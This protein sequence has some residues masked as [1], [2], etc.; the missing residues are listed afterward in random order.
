MTTTQISDKQP[1]RSYSLMLR[2]GCLLLVTAAA[3][4][5][6]DR[7]VGG[8][9]TWVAMA[10]GRYTHGDW[11]A[12]Q[13]NRTAQMKLLDGVG[14]HLT[15][16][17]FMG[18]FS[19]PFNPESRKTGNVL[20]R[21]GWAMQEATGKTPDKSGHENI[22]QV[23]WINQNWLTHAA[24]YACKALGAENPIDENAFGESLI[25]LY[26]FLQAILTALFAYWAA[27]ELGAH[28]LIAALVVAFGVLLS[29]S[30]ID[31]RPNISSILY[32]IITIYLLARWRNGKVR[33][34]F[35]M[36][37]VMILWANVHGGFI[38]AMMVFALA[39][40][41]YVV[42]AFAG[43]WKPLF[44]L[45]GL[46]AVTLIVMSAAGSKTFDEIIQSNRD[47]VKNIEKQKIRL[48]QYY[49]E[50]KI[51]SM[52]YE[53][54]TSVL[55]Q[56]L[57]PRVRQERAIHQTRIFALLTVLSLLAIITCVLWRLNRGGAAALFYPVS[58]RSLKYLAFGGGCVVLIPWFF[59][60]FS[61][62]NLVHPL[63]VATGAEGGEW[64]EVA[65]WLPVWQLYGFGHARYYVP[66]LMLLAVTVLAWWV[67][68]VRTAH[69]ETS[70]SL[71]R[72]LPEEA[73]SGPKVDLAHLAIVAITVAM[74]IQSRRFI[75]LGG[76]IIAPYLAAWL[77]EAIGMLWSGRLSHSQGKRLISGRY[78]TLSAWA[79]GAVLMA[80]FITCLWDVY[81]R[82]PLEGPRLSI[83][84]RM[85]KIEDQPWRAMQ[86][87]NANHL[88]GIVFNEWT[89]GGFITFH[90]TPDP[91]TGEV[92]CK[93]FMDGRAQ[94][95]YD[96]EH[97]RLQNRYRT[98][99]ENMDIEEFHAKLRAKRLNLA[100][101]DMF[102]SSSD[103]LQMLFERSSRW[104]RLY[105]DHR[106]V[107]YADIEDPLNADIVQAFVEDKLNW[108][109]DI[110]HAYN[111][112]LMEIRSPA[113]DVMRQGLG[114]LIALNTDEFLPMHYNAVW[115]AAQRLNDVDAARDYCRQELKRRL[116]TLQ[117]GERFRALDH[118]RAVKN[119]LDILE[120]DAREQG[121]TQ[122][123]QMYQQQS[124][125]VQE[126]LKRYL[127]QRERLLW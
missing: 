42:H 41:A 104:L 86:F 37:P 53:N 27:R 5:S 127:N 33:A 71:R 57:K 38:Y 80:I 14:L 2:L 45:G 108:P 116:D 1:P 70:V 21:F 97:F 94:A 101:L 16:Q 19:R 12:S 115:G 68:C 84:R 93:V 103:N 49:R 124:A 92:P 100:L 113:P 75:L 47:H 121:L 62:E 9:D 87:F 13:E 109:E 48:Q 39:G 107:I 59:S 119:V 90:Q 99:A 50:G 89:H 96:I 112:G 122:Q 15:Q 126:W 82:P 106:Y 64:R 32:A 7:V 63:L 72:P 30:F 11:P 73:S 29:R 20:R 77:T 102:S 105:T 36:I 46:A 3:L 34:M 24:F 114:R 17:D 81:Y 65:E 6:A 56:N 23:G 111:R 43:R 40:G 120:K 54:R 85:V 79:A 69:A 44:L 76:V 35:W 55:E 10:C 123:C 74:S 88:R 95:A 60:P 25:V 91:Q 66:F 18:E 98:F 8:G 83:F 110:L 22:E 26:K 125:G 61:L 28:P 78:L 51:S 52:D 31:L 117:S 118:I 67:M 4:H 58:R